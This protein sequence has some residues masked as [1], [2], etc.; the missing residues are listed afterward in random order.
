MPESGDLVYCIG[1]KESYDLGLSQG[2]MKKRGRGDRYSGGYVWRTRE[3]AQ[4]VADDW[5]G[6]AVYGVRARWG[7]DTVAPEGIGDHHHLLID[8]EIVALEG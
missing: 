6:Y 2:P 8:A 5:P 1:H 3:E 7:V 4:G